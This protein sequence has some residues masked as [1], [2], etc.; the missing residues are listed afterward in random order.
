MDYIHYMVKRITET[1]KRAGTAIVGKIREIV[2]TFK[3]YMEER[4]KRKS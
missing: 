1:A 3:T 2:S 4:K